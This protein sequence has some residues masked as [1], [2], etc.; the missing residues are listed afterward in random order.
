MLMSTDKI[1]TCFT[2]V[3]KG[4]GKVHP[5]TGHEGPEVKQRYSCTLS[6]TSALEGGVG[7]QGHA[8]A[9]LSWKRPGTHCTG[10]W[11]G[12]RASLEGCGKSRPTLGFESRTIQP[13]ASHCTD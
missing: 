10:G 3:D 4:K 8:L 7:V 9:A 6:L 13:I 12:P 2:I 1:R 5:R 11:V